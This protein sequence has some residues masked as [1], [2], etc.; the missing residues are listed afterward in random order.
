[1][2][3]VPQ[4]VRQTPSGISKS[5]NFSLPSFFFLASVLPGVFFLESFA[6][7]ASSSSAAGLLLGDFFVDFLP[8]CFAGGSSPGSGSNCNPG[9]SSA[10][11]AALGATF[12]GADFF[13][14][15]FFGGASSWASARHTVKATP[16]IATSSNITARDIGNPPQHARGVIPIQSM[17]TPQTKQATRYGRFT[18]W[19]RASASDPTGAR[20]NR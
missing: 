11:A 8:G 2:C 7:V 14:V 15:T 13:G 17:P 3:P 10:G 4:H 9:S 16:T 1:M 19:P 20:S 12:L 6:G 18:Y 5:G